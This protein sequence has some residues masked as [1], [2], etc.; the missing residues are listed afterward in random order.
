MHIYNNE[1]W[2]TITTIKVQISRVLMYW[3]MNIRLCNFPSI[4]PF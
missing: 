3:C 1:P 2:I 4:E